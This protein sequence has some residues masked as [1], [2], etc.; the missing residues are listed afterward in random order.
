MKNESCPAK[1][2]CIDYHLKRCEGCAVGDKILELSLENEKL[3]ALLEK[4]RA[5]EKCESTGEKPT[6]AEKRRF[7]EREL[8]VLLSRVDSDIKRAF[9]F[10]S[11]AGDE[12]VRIEYTKKFARN[13]TVTG[14]NL[15]SLTKDVLKRL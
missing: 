3:N 10:T 14:D 13:V 8:S 2:H 15:L 12:F 7:V 4:R 5:D 1:H 9:Y 11:P 6:Y